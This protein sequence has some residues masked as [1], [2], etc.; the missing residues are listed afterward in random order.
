MN[1]RR[2]LT[3][4]LLLFTKIDR[5]HGKLCILYLTLYYVFHIS[6]FANIIIEYSE[7]NAY[8]YRFVHSSIIAMAS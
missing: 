5:L 7:K 2:F 6:V 3:L 4:I 8:R 1:L